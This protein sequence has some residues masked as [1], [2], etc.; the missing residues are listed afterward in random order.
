[1][2]QKASPSFTA[3]LIGLMFGLE[4]QRSG[5][6]G[7]VARVQAHVAGLDP[8]GRQ[9][10]LD[11]IELAHRHARAG[12]QQVGAEKAGALFAHRAF[13][14]IAEKAGGADTA[15]ADDQ[16]R[17]FAGHDQS[18]RLV[19]A[20]HGDAVGPLDLVQ[21]RLHAVGTAAAPIRWSAA[22]RTGWWRSRRW[23]RRSRRRWAR[24]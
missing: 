1:M 17:T 4:R 6:D 16:R 12:E 7:D 14:A 11:Q 18:V 3:L 13:Q 8:L 21:G 10:L 23:R 9:R 5:S 2:R 24:G 19:L 20:D 22:A 15:Y